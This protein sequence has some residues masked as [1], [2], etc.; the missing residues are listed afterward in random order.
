MNYNPSELAGFLPETNL[1]SGGIIGNA[2]AA[3]TYQLN[4]RTAAEYYSNEQR[5]ANKDPKLVITYDSND[6]LSEQI[7]ISVASQGVI[8]DGDTFTLSDGL[9]QATYEFDIV[10]STADRAYGV[11]Q[12]NI[13]IQLLP[14]ATNP[15]IA[16]AIRDTINSAASRAVINLTAA[17][18]GQMLDGNGGEY[19][20]NQSSTILLYG[21]AAVNRIG[22]L[23]APGTG[24]TFNMGGVMGL[25]EAGGDSNR[26]RDQGQIVIASSTFRNSAQ[27]GIVVD[28]AVRNQ[29]ALG[30]NIGD[31]PYP[32]SAA[33]LLTLNNP[34]IAPGVVI[35]GNIVAG[36]QV[37]GIQLGG[38]VTTGTV[39]D[40]V[41]SV[42]RVFNNTIYGINNGSG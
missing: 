2:V 31:R 38:D 32:G 18:D 34:N 28:D 20:A 37:G 39:A 12:G 15:E 21:D 11:N 17:T 8:R 30:A 36:N 3:G 16:R 24:L 26:R 42:A 22:G 14:S 19:V 35:S 40:A 13:S 29:T 4:I 23:A 10:N 27:F 33:N 7:S 41:S 9:N 25:G 1:S 5:L 6:R